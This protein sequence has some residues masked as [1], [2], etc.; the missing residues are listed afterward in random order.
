MFL[1]K[2]GHRFGEDG[3]ES[4]GVFEEDAL[5]GEATLLIEETDVAGGKPGGFR[6]GVLNDG[7][8]D[9]MTV[10]DEGSFKRTELLEV[11]E[12]VIRAE[13]DEGIG[14]GNP[15]AGKFAG[16]FSKGFDGFRDFEVQKRV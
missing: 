2:V 11:A 12:G 3:T 8:P 10:T 1:F 9:A 14:F 13:D 16:D 7:N 4:A 6:A 15:V 5:E